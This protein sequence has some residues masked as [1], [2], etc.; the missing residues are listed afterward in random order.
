MLIFLLKSRISHVYNRSQ[1]CKIISPGEKNMKRLFCIS[2]CLILTC[3]WTA[4]AT[5]GEKIVIPDFST[6]EE[7]FTNARV[8]QEVVK[9]SFTKKKVMNH[10]N[11]AIEGY[12]KV[13]Q[14]FPDDTE[15]T[16]RAYIGIGD[17]YLRMGKPAQAKKHLD[18]ALNTYPDNELLQAI[19]R[20]GIGRC[21][22][23]MEQYESAQYVLKKWLDTYDRHEHPAIKEL[24]KQAAKLYQDAN[25]RW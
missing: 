8:Q 19:A 1:L 24:S 15:F 23:A 20:F 21:Y 18:I 12:K 5:S 4:C 9:F 6:A 13:I 16:P 11:A 3:F 25:E 14:N 2:Y 17:C 7:Q 22:Y 10:Y